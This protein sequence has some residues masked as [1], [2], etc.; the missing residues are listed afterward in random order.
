MGM[1][2]RD[3]RKLSKAEERDHR[4][5][6][7]SALRPTELK[8]YHHRCVQYRTRRNTMTERSTT[9]RATSSHLQRR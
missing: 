4:G 2:T 6:M 1:D 3:R 9:N 8:L 5:A 7:P